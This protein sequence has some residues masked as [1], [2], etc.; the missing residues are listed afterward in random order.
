MEK[1]SSALGCVS[2]MTV[3]ASDKASEGTE[4]A[5]EGASSSERTSC[6]RA[7]SESGP[8]E[9]NAVGGPRGPGVLPLPSGRFSLRVMMVAP[10]PTGA[11]GGRDRLCGRR[12]CGV[13]ITSGSRLLN[14][15][16]K[17]V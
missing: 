4:G 16:Q 15:E 11:V 10:S 8:A 12:S 7:M 1:N 14:G 13:G 6:I 2:C 9:P 5:S 17:L 3:G